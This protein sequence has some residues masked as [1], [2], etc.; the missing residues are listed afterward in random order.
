MDVRVVRDVR[1]MRKRP[2]RMLME[3][4]RASADRA[5]DARWRFDRR[6]IGAVVDVVVVVVIA[7]VA[8]HGDAAEQI[9][10]G[11]PR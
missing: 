11:E 3:R 1:R 8:V 6:F 10:A 5:T 7:I 4:R 2:R 9:S